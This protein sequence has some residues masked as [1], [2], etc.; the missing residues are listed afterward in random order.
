MYMGMF[1][2]VVVEG[3]KLKTSKEV[4]DFLKENNADL[5]N[6]F[7]TK[8]LDNTLSTFKIDK[9]YQ[10]W[11]S[12]PK[13]TGKRISYGSL[14]SGWKDNRSFLER[15][16][17]KFKYKSLG[18]VPK[19]RPELIYTWQ[20][21]KITNTIEIYSYKEINDRYLDVCFIAKIIDGKVK[22]IKQHTATIESVN[23]S[24]KRKA[25]N[26]EFDENMEKQFVR[27]K[28]FTSKWYY[29]VLK[30]TWNPIVFFSRLLIQKVC[31]K[32]NTWTY[33]WYTI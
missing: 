2:T 12:V 20:K 6:D 32:I 5:P 30:E 15:I 23:E 28:E 26:Q 33:R 25:R 27:R 9:N 8:D 18:N 31:Q 21:V 10:L 13:E 19:T 1:D 24:K 7:Q 11:A 22:S 17:Y 3:L 14:F 4:K 16:Y 29:P